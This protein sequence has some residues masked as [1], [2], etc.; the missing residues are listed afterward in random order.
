MN[1]RLFFVWFCILI[2]MEG[3]INEG[4]R[5]KG[6]SGGYDTKKIK[7]KNCSFRVAGLVNLK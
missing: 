7:V 5:K 2:E 3:E 6:Y 4:E 1:S